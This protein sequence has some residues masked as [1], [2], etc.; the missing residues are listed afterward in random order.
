MSG[1]SPS[2]SGYNQINRPG[3]SYDAAGDMTADGASNT[4]S[5]DAEGHLKSFAGGAYIAIFAVCAIRAKRCAWWQAGAGRGSG[6]DGD[7][8]ADGAGYTYGWDAEGRLTSVSGGATVTMQY[9]ALG[10]RVYRTASS[11]SVSYFRDPAGQFLG[12]D[13]GGWNA[14]ILFAGRTLAEYSSGTSGTLYFDHP[15]ALGSEQ[16]WTD[17]AGEKNRG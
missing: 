11:G 10:Q 12:G 4:Y 14:N 5:W 6:W 17:G 16:Q 13:W 15:N 2:V 8:T 1:P 7:M 9:N 3:F